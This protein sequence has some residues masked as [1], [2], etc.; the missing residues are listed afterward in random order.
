MGE[1]GVMVALIGLVGASI[2][3]SEYFRVKSLIF[4]RLKSAL[5]ARPRCARMS[6]SEGR[7]LVPQWSEPTPWTRPQMPPG[8]KTPSPSDY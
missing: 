8:P 5:R 6:A 4:T 7:L 3:V 2:N 1:E